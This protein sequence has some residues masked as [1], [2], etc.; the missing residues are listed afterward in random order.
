MKPEDFR[1]LRH[2]AQYDARRRGYV[3]ISCQGKHKFDS[4]TAASGT[5]RRELRRQAKPYHCGVCGGWH[6]G[7]IQSGRQ[8]RLAREGV[9]A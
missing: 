6:I 1:E 5:M 4:F 7:G 9:C 3:A 2:L 8:A